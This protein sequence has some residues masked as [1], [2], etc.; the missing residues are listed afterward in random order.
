MIYYQARTYVRNARTVRRIINELGIKNIFVK[1]YNFE[2]K[3]LLF[4][5]S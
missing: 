1:G 4:N 2:G 5:K 3:R